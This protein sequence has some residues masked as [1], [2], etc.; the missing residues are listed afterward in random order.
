MKDKH[1]TESPLSRRSLLKGAL[2][3]SSAGLV[4]AGAESC[5]GSLSTSSPLSTSSTPSTSSAAHPTRGAAALRESLLDFLARQPIID[6]HEHLVPERDRV[7]RRVDVLTLLAQYIY[8]DT[9]ATGTYPTVP[10]EGMSAY[11]FFLD[12][13]V[14]YERR[15]AKAWPHLQ[16][17]K[18]GSYYRAAKI[19]LK[20]FYGIDD[21]T[22]H[23]HREATERI[24]AANQPGLYHKVLVDKCRIRACLVQNNAILNQDPADLFIPVTLSTRTA[25]DCGNRDFLTLLEKKYQTSIKDLDGYFECLGRLMREEHAQ[26]AVG[27][28]INAAPNA[29]PDLAA[30]RR[31]FKAFLGGQSADVA[32]RS[33]VMEYVICR[34]GELGWPVA[35]HT[36]VWGDFRQMDPK[37]MIEQ[38]QR[39]P[40]VHFDLYHLGFPYVR[41]SIFIAKS[42]PNATLNLCWT[43][44]ISPEATRQAIGEILD[45]LP[46]N[47]IIAFGG[48][49]GWNVENVFGHLTMARE[50]LAEAFAERI[51]RG[52]MD[53]DAAR[54]ILKLWLWD[55]PRRIYGLKNQGS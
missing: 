42:C 55:T 8:A 40:E 11:N 37:L 10:G 36:G 33:I 12:T 34:S 1:P 50:T 13:R 15:W 49:Y 23:N 21:L 43:Y 28:K 53:E 51:A 52:L 26:G 4:L 47:K 39:H 2:L 9:I 24:R 17:V 25:V 27:A 54:G 46:V 38:I 45:A 41:D 31:S 20:E 5:A 6:A 18:H 35:V 29:A 16:Y 30:A 19:A 32:L 44:I 22:D 3:A 48:D 14:P 7:A